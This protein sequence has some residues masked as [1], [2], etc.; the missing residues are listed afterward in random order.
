MMNNK[1]HQSKTS[2]GRGALILTVIAIVWNAL[3]WGLLIPETGFSIAT[4]FKVASVLVGALLA[5]G[6]AQRWVSRLRGTGVTLNLTHDPVPHGE[7]TTAVFTLGRPLKVQAWTLLVTIDS[8][9]EDLSGFGRVWERKFA[10]T[11]VPVMIAGEIMVQSVRADFT[12]PVDLPSTQDDF[13]CVSL[14]L[15]GDGMKWPFVIETRPATASEQAFHGAAFDAPQAAADESL[16]LSEPEAELPF[17]LPV[18]HRGG[19]KWARHG[20]L[21]VFLG[22]VGGLALNFLLPMGSSDVPVDVAAD[23]AAEVVEGA[24]EAEWVVRALDVGEADASARLSTRVSTPEFEVLLSNWLIDDWRLRAHMQGVAQ[25]GQGQLRVRI[26][27][28][29]LMPV[30]PCQRSGECQVQSI[31]LLLSQAEADGRYITLAQSK[32]L[33]WAVDLAQDPVAHRTEGEFVLTLPESLSGD[34]DVRLQLMVQ[35]ASPGAPVNPTYPSHGNHMGLQLALTAAAPSSASARMDP[36]DRVG[37]LMEAVRAHCQ[38][39]IRFRLDSNAHSGRK[40]LD[41]ALMEAIKHYNGAAVS[42][43]LNAGASPHA[44]DPRQKSVT[45]LGLAAAGDQLD[46]LNALIKTGAMVN[47]RA[48]NADQQT[49]TPLSQALKRDAAL[50]VD[51]L[52]AA[53]AKLHDKDQDGWSVMHI[54]AREGATDSLKVLVRA[55]GNVNE[56]AK[57]HHRKTA[58][59]TAVQ[60]APQATIEAMLAAGAD[61]RITDDQDKN[62]CD[63]AQA[64]H[65]SAAIQARVCG[66]VQSSASGQV[67]KF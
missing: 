44:A 65:R 37:S 14:L 64:A 7:P 28:L 35:T 6:A 16:D 67:D 61:T 11:A 15:E 50:A 29:T 12:L 8:P 36:C 56:K 33:P 27:Q 62:A 40:E 5:L 20:A 58:F 39:Q 9:D 46:V 47:H 34:H 23:V 25:V 45:A 1:M 19:L 59:H 10:V 57:G 54:A 3:V 4:W 49:V 52:L 42:L 32:P 21:A 22:V 51:R 24:N 31:R 13:W 43:L 63:W 2:A 17:P 38:G 48:M 18:R 60:F 55:G 53:G 30:G 41:A 26:Q 66:G